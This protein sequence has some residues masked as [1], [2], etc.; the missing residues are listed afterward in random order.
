MT[1]SNNARSEILARIRSAIGGNIT[2]AVAESTWQTIPRQYRQTGKYSATDCLHLFEDRL[3]DYGAGV[4]HCPPENLA[5]TIAE[6]LRMRK[7]KRIFVAPDIDAAALPAE[8]RTYV[9]ANT[10][11]YSQ[12]DSCDGVLTGCTVAIAETGTLALCHDAS[13]PPIH[14]NT[15]LHPEFGQSRRAVS[16]IP[17]YHLCVVRAKDV[18]ET[19]PQ[20]IGLLDRH[21][22]QP[23]TLISGPSATADIEMTRV[24]GVHGPRTLDVIIV[25]G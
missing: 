24:Q 7:K 19:V 6:T 12:I 11:S 18:V 8:D 16:L 20:A 13:A 25:S 9:T 17:D 23:I 4:F 5:A 1:E 2:P 3:R 21:K 22:L 14:S 15:F 10:L